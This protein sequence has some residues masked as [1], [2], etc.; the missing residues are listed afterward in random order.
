[1]HRSGKYKLGLK[2]LAIGLILALAI[3]GLSYELKSARIYPTGKITI[4]SGEKKVGE[5][6]KEAP[7]PKGFLIA[8]DGRCGVKMESVYLVAEDKSLFSVAATA[9]LRKL[10]IKEGKVYFA[11][12]GNFPSLS[13]ITPTGNLAVLDILLN[14]AA[15]NQPLKG[16]VSVTQKGSELGVIEGG[17]MVISTQQG[18]MMIKSGQRIILA[19]VDMDVGPPVEEQKVDEK[20]GQESQEDQEVQEGQEVKPGMSGTTKIIVGAVAVG[21]VAA[22]VGALAGGG[23]G[24]GGGDGGGPI[25]PS[26]PTP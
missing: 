23:G 2:F 4:Y 11:M 15:N 1:M 7:L 17:S 6:S 19:Q 10:R 25:S 14:A 12:S 22:G 3:P 24:G 26:S 5:F 20:E 21:A 9:N 13:F 16:Y 8:T 18:E